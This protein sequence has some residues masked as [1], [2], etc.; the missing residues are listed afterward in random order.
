[1]DERSQR[2]VQKEFNKDPT[3]IV[4]EWNNVTEEW[5]DGVKLI[6]GNREE[7]EWYRYT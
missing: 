1:M 5:T 6:N 3:T 2:T 4:L 7:E